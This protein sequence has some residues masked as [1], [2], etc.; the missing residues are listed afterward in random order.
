[1]KYPGIHQE[2]FEEQFPPPPGEKRLN[3]KQ[4]FKMA[5][6]RRNALQKQ[7]MKERYFRSTD[8]SDLRRDPAMH[9]PM[10]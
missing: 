8:H 2:E 5:Q 10:V 1:M 9:D 3:T 6:W 7:R 4:S